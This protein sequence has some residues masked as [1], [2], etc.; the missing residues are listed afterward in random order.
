VSSTGNNMAIGEAKV[1][2]LRTGLREPEESLALN[3]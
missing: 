2:H 3:C 1:S